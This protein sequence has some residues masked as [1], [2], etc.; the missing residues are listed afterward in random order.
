MTCFDIV[1]IE[2]NEE[3]YLLDFGLPDTMRI[4]VKDD[5]MD[6][7]WYNWGPTEEAIRKQINNIEELYANDVKV[8]DF[9]AFYA[10]TKDPLRG[11]YEDFQADY[12][13][14]G[15][16][17]DEYIIG[18]RIPRKKQVSAKRV[19]VVSSV[20][21]DTGQIDD[22]DLPQ[23]FTLTLD[24]DEIGDTT[25]MQEIA[26]Y[27]VEDISDETG[28]LVEGFYFQ[29]KMPDGTLVDLDAEGFVCEMNDCDATDMCEQC[30]DDGHFYCWECCA[31][32]SQVH[33]NAEDLEFTDWA[34]QES[35]SHGKVSL[36]EWADHEIKKHGGKMSF[37]DWAK[38]ED[39]SHIDRFGAE[40]EPSL[41]TNYFFT[42]L[43]RCKRG[44]N[45]KW[46]VAFINRG[47]VTSKLK[48]WAT[49]VFCVSCGK[50]IHNHV[51]KTKPTKA[52]KAKWLKEVYGAEENEECEYCGTKEEEELTEIREDSWDGPIVLVCDRCLDIAMYGAEE[53]KKDSC[54]CGATKSKPCACMI[55]G[56]MECNATCPCSGNIDLGLE[57]KGAENQDMMCC[58]D[59]MEFYDGK[60]MGGLYDYFYCPVCEESIETKEFAATYHFQ[61]RAI[62]SVEAKDEEAAW[63]RFSWKDPEEDWDIV[64]V[65]DAETSGQWEIGEQL[66]EAQMNS[67]GEYYHPDG[68]YGD[69]GDAFGCGP[70]QWY[71][72]YDIGMA[73]AAEH[74]CIECDEGVCDGCYDSKTEMCLEC[75]QDKA[76][77]K[78][79]TKGIDTFTEPFEESSLDSGTAKSIVVGIGI[80]LLAC[81]GYNK[82]K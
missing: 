37:Q 55:L 69:F 11:N 27:L 14:G 39:K 20:D 46:K 62:T 61:N 5:L 28:W 16:F 38:H 59:K 31:R 32:D 74:T 58:G 17:E 54:C 72:D 26:D 77:V 79:A 70:C 40:Y 1:N 47:R 18:R 68:D 51:S 81:F 41:D 78:E 65:L 82:M 6:T 42:N 57:K 76:T 75:A 15:K 49:T 13:K 23:D 9:T 12:K 2:Y 45:H 21:Y 80:G 25:D 22:L 52:H 3:G 8:V 50:V 66:E 7:P 33:W 34:N 48:G 63:D 35:K 64:D 53:L 60:S 71:G 10:G 43:E 44:G 36:K 24:I 73:P 4:C 67:E 30:V 56:I 19:F 29:E